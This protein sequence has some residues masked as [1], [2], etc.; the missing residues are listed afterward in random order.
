VAAGSTG[1]GG[2]ARLMPNLEPMPVDGEVFFPSLPTPTLVDYARM[3]KRLTSGDPGAM[4][5]LAAEGVSME[6]ITII[7]QTW[8]AL[9]AARTDLALRFSQLVAAP[10]A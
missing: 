7:N 9:F 1:G 6:M 3:F 4:Q 5:S 2:P 10:W 8:S